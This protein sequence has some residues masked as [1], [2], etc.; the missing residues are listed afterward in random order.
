MIIYIKANKIPKTT[1]KP[2]IKYYNNKLKKLNQL[3][4]YIFQ[5]FESLKM[6]IYVTKY[7]IIFK[8]CDNIYYMLIWLSW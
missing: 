7:L 5:K 2:I 1:N 3:K 6:Y 8:I 4:I